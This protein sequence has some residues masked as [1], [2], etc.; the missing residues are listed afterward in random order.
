MSR[1]V[2][3]RLA[4]VSVLVVLSMWLQP[5]MATIPPQTAAAGTAPGSPTSSLNLQGTAP[6]AL[7]TP[8]SARAAKLEA[9]RLVESMR[10]PDPDQTPPGK[11]FRKQFILQ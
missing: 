9:I 3:V 6:L 8:G 4:I 11:D 7:V 5:V 10:Y 1:H 2:R